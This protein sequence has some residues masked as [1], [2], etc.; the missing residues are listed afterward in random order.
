MTI[1]QRYEFLAAAT[2]PDRP[3]PEQAATVEAARKVLVAKAA[4]DVGFFINVFCWTFDPRLKDPAR[5]YIPF[6][7][8]PKQEEYV[9]WVKDH[10]DRGEDGLT[11]KSRDT[12]ATWC[13]L[14]VILHGWLFEMG[15]TALLGSK[16]VDFVDKAGDPTT[17]FWKFL[18]MVNSLPDWMQPAG[19]KA[20]KPWRTYLKIENPQN[21]SV[22]TGMASGEDFG[23][24]GRFKVVF[25]DEFAAWEYAAS[26]WT[27]SGETTQCRLPVSTPRGMNFFGHLANPRSASEGID[28][29]RIHWKDDPRHARTEVGPDGREFYP[30]EVKARRRYDYDISMMAQELEIDYNRSVS[31]RVY[32]QSDYAGLGT[33]RYAPLL[34]TYGAIDVGRDTTALGWFQWNAKRGRY[35]MLDYYEN[36]GH[37]MD[38]YVP[39]LTGDIP[40]GHPWT[41]QAWE[42]KVIERHKGWLLEAVYGDPSGDYRGMATET[43]PY[44]ILARH[45]IHVHTNKGARLFRTRHHAARKLLLKLDVDAERCD[46]WLT[47]MRNYA[48]PKRPEGSQSTGL[49]E[50]PVHNEHSHGATMFEWMAVAE[51]H[52][53][54]R[55]VDD[56]DITEERRLRMAEHDDDEDDDPMFAPRGIAG[57]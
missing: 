7:L 2:M 49:N 8:F 51:P 4:R 35:E 56:D 5:R 36:K 34:K 43:T 40:V 17:L 11:E 37:V 38:F 18:F 33:Y 27:A 19:W 55:V 6:L 12:G 28:K 45:G 10:I 23:R 13:V 15:F 25:P 14:A 53:Y 3:T 41:Y 50:E 24:S 57:Y 30:Y 9:A 46:R 26:A 48:F 52:L 21:R 44:G 47:A 39:F 54:D 20:D 22:I 1:R 29:F 32:P 42:L 31:G 16:I